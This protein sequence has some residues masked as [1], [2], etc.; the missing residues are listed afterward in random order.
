MNAS[1]SRENSPP[2]V[3]RR[4]VPDLGGAPRREGRRAGAAAPPA[5]RR[6]SS[7]SRTR[8]CTYRSPRPLGAQRAAPCPRT[9]S[10]SPDWVPGR[11]ST[12]V[13][14]SRV[15]RVIVV[16]SA[17]AVIGTVTMQC[18]SSPRRSNIGCGATTTSTNRSPAGP[19][20]GPTS[21]SPDSWMRVPVST[22]ARDLDGQRARACAP[23]RRR[24]TPGR[25]AGSSCRSPGT[26]GTDATS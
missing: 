19:P 3:L 7:A 15:S 9:V 12:S 24:S 6:A 13:V 1:F 25:G 21:P 2:C 18:R 14:P 20:L 5:R 4:A 8:R 10:V 17:A 16:P 22:P 26:A 11:M 23:V